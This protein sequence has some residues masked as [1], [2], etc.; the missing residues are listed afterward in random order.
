VVDTIYTTRKFNL[1]DLD[2]LDIHPCTLTLVT[3]KRNI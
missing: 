1:A 3:L 2:T